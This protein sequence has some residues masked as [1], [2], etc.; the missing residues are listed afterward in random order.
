VLQVN[1]HGSL[2]YGLDWVESIGEG[3]YYD[4]EVPDMVKKMFETQGSDIMRDAQQ[5]LLQGT[6]SKTAPPKSGP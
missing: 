5:F 2:N 4:L 3:K 6:S 1:Y